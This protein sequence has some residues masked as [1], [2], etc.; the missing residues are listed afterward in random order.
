MPPIRF[1]SLRTH[2]LMTLTMA[3]RGP[4]IGKPIG[5]ASGVEVLK[6]CVRAYA[7]ATTCMQVPER[8][9]TGLRLGVGVGPF[10]ENYTLEPDRATPTP[11]AKVTATM[12]ILPRPL[13]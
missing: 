6:P 11:A 1:L 13:I 10:A 3:R 7:K 2:P 5:A 4:P 9:H 12:A 8:N